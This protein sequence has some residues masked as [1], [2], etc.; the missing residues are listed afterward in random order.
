MRKILLYH[1][2]REGKLHKVRAEEGTFYEHGELDSRIF[3]T[4]PGDEELKELGRET[5]RAELDKDRK[6]EV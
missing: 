1:G 6:V 5:Q 2:F 3:D 4:H